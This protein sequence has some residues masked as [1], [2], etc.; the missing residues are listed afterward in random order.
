[1]EKKITPLE[2][3]NI[4]REVEKES[5]DIKKIFNTLVRRKKILFLTASVLFS[6]GTV[7][8]IYQRVRNP[9]FKGKLQNFVRQQYGPGSWFMKSAHENLAGHV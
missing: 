4:N 9:I 6:I 2:K 8:L 5:F 1:M 7:N 3:N